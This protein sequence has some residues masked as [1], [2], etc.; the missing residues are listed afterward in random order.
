MLTL[1]RELAEELARARV[2]IQV[3]DADTALF[4]GVPTGAPGFSKP[5]TNMLVKRARRGLPFLVCVDDDLS[6]RGGCPE[7]A[8]AF[9]SGAVQQGWRV[10]TTGPRSAGDFEAAVERGLN[11]VGFNGREADLEPPRRAAADRPPLKAFGTDLSGALP[12]GEG[13]PTVGREEE[14]RQ[15]LACVLR[16]SQS[17]L[18]LVLG[19]SGVG[20]SNL[21]WQVARQLAT[22]QPDARLV[23]VDLDEVMAGTL[24]DSERES[25]LASL[26]QEAAAR[27]GTV[28]ALE[29]IETALVHLPRGPSLLAGALDRGGRLI[30]TALPDRV[31]SLAARTLARRI[32]VVPVPECTSEEALAILTAL[33]PRLAEHHGVGVPEGLLAA[34]VRSAPMA[35]GCLP[36][37]AIA[38]LDE[39]ASRAALAG[40]G[41]VSGD[42]VVAAGLAVAAGIAEPAP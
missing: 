30:G 31:Q 16:W 33:R 15:V 19:P 40:A 9:A 5:R 39:A 2:Q 21:L 28:L 13:Q 42:D 36:A 6:Y 10:I 14:C 24:F 37:R 22:R 11:A 4:K 34:V 1:G 38:V 18:A 29:H 27:E 3:T 32:Q 25:L 12:R 35:A 20:K 8:R 26:L 41:E 7:L 23:S 17:R